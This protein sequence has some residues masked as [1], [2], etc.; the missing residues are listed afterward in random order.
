MLTKIFDNIEIKISNIH[1]RYENDIAQP[2]YSCGITIR[3]INI[4]TMDKDWQAH[5]F[6]DRS[7]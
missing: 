5:M 7:N 2:Y 1:V 6:I 4:I 3:S